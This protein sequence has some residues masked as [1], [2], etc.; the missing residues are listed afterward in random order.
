M[1]T[2]GTVTEASNRG[3]GTKRLGEGGTIREGGSGKDANGS[4]DS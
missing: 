4:G 2:S 1:I 3:G